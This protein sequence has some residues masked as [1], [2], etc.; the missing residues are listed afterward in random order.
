ML[1]RRSEAASESEKICEGM[2][3]EMYINDKFISFNQFDE[4]LYN[5]YTYNIQ[6]INVALLKNKKFFLFF[7]FVFIF[8][9]TISQTVMHADCVF[10]IFFVNS[11]SSIT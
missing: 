2:H 11:Y 5:I 10:C 7:V 1:V 9:F 8:H 3:T 4:G 6:H